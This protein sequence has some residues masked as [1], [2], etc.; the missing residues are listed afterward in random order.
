MPKESISTYNYGRFASSPYAS[1]PRKVTKT[2]RIT[3]KDYSN[4]SEPYSA[5][6]RPQLSVAIS[7]C[8]ANIYYSDRLRDGFASD[9]GKFG[10]LMSHVEIWAFKS[11]CAIKNIFRFDQCHGVD[12]KAWANRDKGRLVSS[13]GVVCLACQCD[14]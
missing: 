12:L 2:I 11:K 5:G 13:T 4:F 7:S 9:S 10:Y 1:L 8:F 14:G 3:K 6:K